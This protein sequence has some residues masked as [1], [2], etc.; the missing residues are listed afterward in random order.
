MRPP[1]NLQE[2]QQ[3]L[4]AAE[5]AMYAIEAEWV[6]SKRKR[7]ATEKELDALRKM[8]RAAHHRALH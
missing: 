3:Q 6:E 7:G 5:E 8:F 1:R 4:A 2:A